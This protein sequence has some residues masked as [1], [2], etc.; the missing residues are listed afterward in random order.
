VLCQENGGAKLIEIAKQL[1]VSLYSTVSQTLG[2]FNAL[3]IEDNE[4]R[5]IYIIS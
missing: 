1:N 4:V 3:M 2:R 5:A